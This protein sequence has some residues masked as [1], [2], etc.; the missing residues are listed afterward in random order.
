MAKTPKQAL[1]WFILAVYLGII[2]ERQLSL[3]MK[4]SV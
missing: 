3:G 1:L 4:F 2:I